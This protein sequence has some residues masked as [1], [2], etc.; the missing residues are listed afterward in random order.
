[1]AAVTVGSWEAQSLAG[2]T[3]HVPF[4][5]RPDKHNRRECNRKKGSIQGMH[6]SLTSSQR[7]GHLTSATSAFCFF[8]AFSCHAK[9]AVPGGPTA[10]FA[11]V[12]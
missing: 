5:K 3:R 12:R 7:H 1:M 8:Y 9:R 6:L 4:P 10:S 2:N 11:R